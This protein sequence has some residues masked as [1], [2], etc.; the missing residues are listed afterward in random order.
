MHGLADNL[1]HP[2]SVRTALDDAD[3][4]IFYSI[5]SAQPGLAGVHLGNGFI[6]Q[7]VDEHAP[8]VTTTSRRS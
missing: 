3:A 5:T 4:A 6:K 2:S 7:V 1:P 8:R